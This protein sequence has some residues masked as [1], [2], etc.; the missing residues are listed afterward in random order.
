MS[1]VNKIISMD[2]C[3]INITEIL[4][5]NIFSACYSIFTTWL[6]TQTNIISGIMNFNLL[7]IAELIIIAV[8]EVGTSTVVGNILIYKIYG[9]GK[10]VA[11]VMEI[12]F[13]FALKEVSSIFEFLP[14][15]LFY[16]SQI[17]MVYISNTRT[18]I[19]YTMIYY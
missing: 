3:R 12:S 4:V 1:S 19:V 11:G 14:T 8:V 16:Q 13:F 2:R 15:C 7:L 5:S 17:D 18:S 10:Y 9:T 6:L